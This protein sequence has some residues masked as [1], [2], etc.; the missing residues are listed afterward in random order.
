MESDW[1]TLTVTMPL[2][3]SI[4]FRSVLEHLIERFHQGFC[5]LRFLVGY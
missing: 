1:E 2:S 3:Y 4:I 5:L